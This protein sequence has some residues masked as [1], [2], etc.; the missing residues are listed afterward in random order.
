MFLGCWFLLFVLSLSLTLFFSPSPFFLLFTEK[1]NIP[2]FIATSG[3]DWRV[4]C[5]ESGIWKSRDG[6]KPP[7]CTAV[8]DNISVST[9]SSSFFV[10]SHK[11]RF[12]FLS[13]FCLNYSRLTRHAH[14]Q[15]HFA[16][17]IIPFVF[18]SWLHYEIEHYCHCQN[19][20]RR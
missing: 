15:C 20:R 2:H 1:L 5:K 6:V 13:C 3:N 10:F 18:Q 14:V 7:Q 16:S 4:Y 12:L 9:W 17:V 8:S 19:G 11:T